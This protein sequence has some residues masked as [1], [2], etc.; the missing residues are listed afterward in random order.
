VSDQPVES[1][2]TDS[3]LEAANA[4]ARMNPPTRNGTTPDNPLDFDAK[5]AANPTRKE[6]RGIKW[7]GK[8]YVLKLVSEAEHIRYHNA[9]SKHVRLQDGKMVGITGG[10]ELDSFL[11]SLCMFQVGV[12]DQGN[13]VLRPVSLKIL[14]STHWIP[15][16]IKVLADEARKLNKL[17][18]V[19]PQ[20]RRERIEALERQLADLREQE[21]AEAELGNS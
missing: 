12:S 19:T 18:A 9:T 11:L 4:R 13:E 20:T 7:Q 16:Q 14:Q 8:E 1:V 3:I 21:E 5:E 2:R 10:A 6:V 17:V 15:E